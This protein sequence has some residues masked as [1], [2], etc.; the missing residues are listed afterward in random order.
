MP[1]YR[2]PG[3]VVSPTALGTYIPTIGADR[4]IFIQELEP[5]NEKVDDVLAMFNAAVTS[6]YVCAAM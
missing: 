2:S 4:Y 6:P 5:T 1:S 3:S